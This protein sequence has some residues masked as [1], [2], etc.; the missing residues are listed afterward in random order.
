MKRI[1]FVL[2]LLCL[3]FAVPAFAQDATPE[4]TPDAPPV[5]V[6]GE[7]PAPP[8]IDEALENLLRV[9]FAVGIALFVEAPITVVI[10]SIIK[11][12][13]QLDFFNARTWAAIVAVILWVL[14]TVAQL[15][16]YEAQFTSLLKILETVLPAVASL[17]FALLGAGGI[18]QA[19]VRNNAAVVSYQKPPVRQAHAAEGVD[20]PR[21]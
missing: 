13:K 20:L 3:T 19:A 21:W 4:P 2:F 18:Y 6:V 12:F 17:V 10:V 14:L 15:A 11:R 9:V 5:D 8:N 16:G 1:A 7:E